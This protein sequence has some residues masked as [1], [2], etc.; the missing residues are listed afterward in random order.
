MAPVSLAFSPDLPGGHEA[1]TG[2]VLSGQCAALL[3]G[4]PLLGGAACSWRPQAR[5]RGRR[6]VGGSLAH[7]LEAVVVVA[8]KVTGDRQ[9]VRSLGVRGRRSGA[10]RASECIVEAAADQLQ[11]AEAEGRIDERSS[12]AFDL[13]VQFVDRVEVEEWIAPPQL[14]GSFE[15]CDLLERIADPSR[16]FPL[17]R[18]SYARATSV[19][20]TGGGASSIVSPWTAAG[21][22]AAAI[23][24]RVARAAA[25][26]G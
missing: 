21:A 18:W 23:V 24:R 25:A 14:D 19:S 20:T 5:R 8:L 9:A 26:A 15:A 6:A 11:F 10:F 1:E 2:S 7:R 4:G 3:R 12:D 16:P 22:V 13:A 17:A